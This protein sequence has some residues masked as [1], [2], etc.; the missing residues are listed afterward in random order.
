MSFD[1]DTA[2]RELSAGCYEGVLV[3]SWCSPRGPLGGYV[4]AVV[5]RG[6]TA[7]VADPAR[8]ARSLRVNFVRPSAP[9]VVRLW[10]TVEQAGRSL[11]VVSGR[12]EQRGKLIALAT[13]VF[14]VP[15]PGPVLCDVR[16]P[17]VAPASRRC[18]PTHADLGRTPPLFAGQLA[19]E[20]VFP[21][22]GAARAESGGWL[23]L[24]ERRP[25]DAV[26]V[27][28]LADA[29]GAAPWS[30]WPPLRGAPPPTVEMSVLLRGSLP[31]P[32]TLLLGHFRTRLVREGCF[33]ED[34][35]LWAPDGQLVAQSRQ[36]ALLPA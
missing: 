7:A 22:V 2:V 32:D 21:V 20:P 18:A 25:V 9:G 35:E 34:G 4:M 30:R 19:M 13:A 5:L 15:R 29:W 27:A 33:E 36:L 23:G 10:A 28:L 17:E 11:T 26:A 1:H 24:L 14:A 6:L 3:G 8:P 12:L 31:L 16:M